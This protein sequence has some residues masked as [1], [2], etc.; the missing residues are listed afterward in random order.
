MQRFDRRE[1]KDLVLVDLLELLVTELLLGH[2]ALHR[3]EEQHLVGQ[4]LEVGAREVELLEL[5]VDGLGRELLV[6]VR[7]DVVD[8]GRLDRDVVRLGVVR[9]QPTLD[10][11]A[12]R[13]TVAH[14]LLRLALGAARRTP[15][16]S[17]RR[18]T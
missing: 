7:D 4:I 11:V 6:E 16:G 10:H 17:G 1:A 13:E 18:G 2:G 15:A 12:E 5:A 8:L 14:R 9:D 3:L